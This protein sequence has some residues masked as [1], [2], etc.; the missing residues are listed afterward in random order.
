MRLRQIKVA[1]KDEVIVRVAFRKIL[2]ILD[3]LFWILSFGNCM[4][5]DDG[6]AFFANQKLAQIGF[7]FNLRLDVWIEPTSS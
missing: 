2:E 4:E 7:S 5:I 1:A 3:F 6:H